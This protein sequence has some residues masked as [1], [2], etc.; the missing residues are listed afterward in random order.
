M[1]Q[2]AYRFLGLSVNAYLQQHHL[3]SHHELPLAFLVDD[4]LSL[5]ATGM[6]D[7][8]L[9]YQFS[10]TGTESYLTEL[11]LL[12]FRLLAYKSAGRVRGAS[13]NVKLI[14]EPYSPSTT[15]QDI[16]S[17]QTRFSPAE[18]F[19][20]GQFVISLGVFFMFLLIYQSLIDFLF[21]CRIFSFYSYAWPKTTFVY[22]KTI[23]SEVP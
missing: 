11:E 6:Q 12:P 3:L 19:E 16:Y 7:S 22:W 2:I 13:P 20:D 14:A 21:S 18:A 9:A 5:V 8:S 10:Q 17:K 4:L 1:E 23:L 15:I